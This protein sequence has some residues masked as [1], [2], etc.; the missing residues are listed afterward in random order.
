[1]VLCAHK[2]ALRGKL[3]EAQERQPLR[4]RD[5]P[6]ALQAW[7]YFRGSSVGPGSSCSSRACSSSACFGINLCFHRLLT[8][9]SFSCPLWLEHTLATLAVCS[10]QDSPPHWVAAHRRHHEFA[11]E[12]DDPHSPLA[13]FFWAHMGWLLVKKDDMSRAAADRALR[14]GH[15]PRSVLCVARP[16]Q[17]LDQGRAAVVAGVFRCGLCLRRCC[18]AELCRTPRSSA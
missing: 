3:R 15:H 5:H 14:Q 18:P 7:R 11:D 10:V 9:R 12:E 1:M 16:A 13:G 8:H 6:P 4:I 17:Q 2:C